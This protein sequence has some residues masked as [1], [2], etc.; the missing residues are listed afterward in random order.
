MILLDTN[1][2]AR[3]TD[4][5]NP[6][7]ALARR[8][9]HVLLGHGERLIVVPQNL[10]EFW[11][12]ATRNPGPPPAGQNGLGMTPDQVSQWL[13]FFQRRFTLLPDHDELFTRWHALVKAL[14]V[15]GLKSY[16]ARLV[17][18][19]QGY[20]ITQLL[21]FNAGDFKRFPVTVIDPASL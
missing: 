17:T 19:M 12:V 5:G 2:L 9:V 7:C 10:Y 18:A 1:V 21:T 3:M 6:H 14:G 8:A 11:A 20:G 16:D 13:G 4:S 15:K